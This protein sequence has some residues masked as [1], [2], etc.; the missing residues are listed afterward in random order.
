MSAPAIVP[1]LPF[2]D[3]NGFP[4]PTVPEAV[5]PDIDQL[6]TE[7]DT[8][9]DNIYTEKQ[10]RLLT[11]PLYIS[12]EGPPNHEPFLALANVGLFYNA[13]RPPL[14]PDTLLSVGVKMEGDLRDK[15]NRSYFMWIADKPPDVV[16]EIVSDRRGGEEDVKFQTYARIGVLY[17]VIYDPDNILKN[18]ILRAYSLD[19]RSY[20]PI[21]SANFPEVGLGLTLWTGDYET[22]NQQWLRWCG[23]DGDPIPTGKER[24][25]AETGNAEDERKKAEDERKKAEDERKKAEAEARRADTAEERLRRLEAQLRGLGADPQT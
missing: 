2:H 17:Y 25:D 5:I 14:V 19:R 3:Q 15:T 1:P 7:D 8:P 6:V 22:Y 24:V 10:Q 18:G 23:P 13:H 11:E 21:D 12:W 20:R 16:I 4:L 9:V